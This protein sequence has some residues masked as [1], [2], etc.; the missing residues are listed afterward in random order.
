[1]K[2]EIVAASH[3]I[4]KQMGAIRR[5]YRFIIVYNKISDLREGD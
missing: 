5:Y 4:Y 1:M 2:K 3:Y